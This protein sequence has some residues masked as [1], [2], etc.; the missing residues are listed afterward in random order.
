MS[1]LLLLLL[2]ILMNGKQRVHL[3]HVARARMQAGV[4]GTHD[5]INDAG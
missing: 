3:G 2:P 4:Q 5:I 1:L